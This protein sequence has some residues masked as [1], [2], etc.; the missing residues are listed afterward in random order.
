MPCRDWAAGQELIDA[1]NHSKV[2][3]YVDEDH[4][5]ACDIYNYDAARPGDMAG[6]SYIATISLKGLAAK[7]RAEA[8]PEHDKQLGKQLKRKRDF[9]ASQD[10]F[11][12][13]V[14]QGLYE[15]DDNE[16]VLAVPF[17]SAEVAGR[18]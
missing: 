17:T 3:A 8:T 18:F 11:I 15:L 9:A 4:P 10:E 12:E 7:G 16:T 5:E 14:E 2:V 1:A 13:L 6:D